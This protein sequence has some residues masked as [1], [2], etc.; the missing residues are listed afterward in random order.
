[1]RCDLTEDP[2]VIAIASATGIDAYGVVGRL[3]RVW[4]WASTHTRDG[5]ARMVTASFI[6]ALVSVTSFARA[7]V[8]AGWLVIENDGIVFPRFDAHNSKS[9]KE[10]ALNTVRV[11]LKRAGANRTKARPEKRREEK[12]IQ[13]PTESVPRAAGEPTGFVEFWSAYPKHADKADARKA[14]VKLS[15]GDALRLE[16]LRAV[17]SQRRSEQ[18]TREGGRFI[19]HPAT[20]LGG[21]RWEDEL[22]EDQGDDLEAAALRQY[23]AENAKGVP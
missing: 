15:P 13:T 8:N 18:W 22:P 4:S 2:S 1:M 12:R 9:A 21:R 3:H 20:W 6:D 16:I 5:H 17:E 14:W 7:M 23:R 11:S 19:P 10:R